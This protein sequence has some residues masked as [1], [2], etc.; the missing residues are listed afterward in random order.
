M[1]SLL[2][3]LLDEWQDCARIER[4]EHLRYVVDHGYEQGVALRLREKEGDEG[5]K[6]KGHV[7]ST[8]TTSACCVWMTLRPLYKPIKGP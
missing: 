6:N 3:E 4:Q 8:A 1:P 2:K 5:R 7:M